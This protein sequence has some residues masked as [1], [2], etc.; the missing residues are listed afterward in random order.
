MTTLTEVLADLTDAGDI[1]A[2]RFTEG[3]KHLF[4]QD[5]AGYHLP[6]EPPTRRDR[7]RSQR[8]DETLFAHGY[9]FVGLAYTDRPAVEWLHF[10]RRSP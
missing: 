7:A 6:D 3:G 8:I 9:C 4:I 2:C 1:V 5:A 10:L